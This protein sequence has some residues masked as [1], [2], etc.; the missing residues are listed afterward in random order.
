LSDLSGGKHTAVSAGVSPKLGRPIDPLVIQVI[1]EV[2]YSM[3]GNV[4]KPVSETIVKGAD[5]V[6]S[7]K[8][9]DELPEFV[10]HHRNVHYWDVADPARQSLQFHRQIRDLVKSK[11]ESLLAE[12]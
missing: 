2:G 9:A 8:S 5:M 12:I 4:R 6:I 11:V 3:D 10:R 1:K 7:F